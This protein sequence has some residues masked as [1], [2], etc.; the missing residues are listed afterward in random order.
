MKKILVPEPKS[1]GLILSYKCNCECKQCMY[2]GS[3]KW[4]ADWIDEKDL[5]II[6]AQLSHTIQPSLYGPKHVSLNYGLHFTGGEPFL[7]YELLLRSVELAHELKIPS[8][9]VET[10][11]YWCVNDEITRYKLNKL[12]KHGLRGILISVNPFMLEYIPFE[13]TKRTIKISEEIFGK[14]VMVYQ[15]G[16]YNQFKKFGFIDK[17]PLEKYIKM[18]S[19]EDLK[20]R[21]E[22][23][24]MGRAPYRLKNWYVKYPAK[25]FFDESCAAELVRGWH[26]HFDNYGNY[27]PGYCGGLSWGE[28]KNLDSMCGDGI[29]LNEFPILKALIIDGIKDLYEFAVKD[30][31]YEEIAEGYNSKCHLCFDIRKKIIQRTTNFKELQ[32]KEFYLYI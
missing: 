14:D 9:F 5:E 17:V 12:K 31:G 16:Y 29:N 27:M 2:F 32:P 22:I 8:T 1:G 3:P 11:C 19:I 18:V 21:V 20:K 7:N 13:K 4:S 28:V 30:F 23:L 15:L 6:L 10:N 24:R 26:V 25:Y